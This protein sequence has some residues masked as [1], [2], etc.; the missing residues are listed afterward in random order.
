QALDHAT[1][2]LLAASIID[3]LV[4]RAADRRGR[5]PAPETQRKPRGPGCDP[6]GR[7]PAGTAQGG[8]E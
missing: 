6:G 3:A 5:G 2:Y 1:G 8:R 7:A 4:D